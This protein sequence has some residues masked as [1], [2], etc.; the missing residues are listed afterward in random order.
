MKNFNYKLDKTLLPKV[1][2]YWYTQ[3]DGDCY[4][5]CS[6]G[7]IKHT[8]EPWMKAYS[9]Q[10]RSYTEGKVPMGYNWST[11]ESDKI[12]L[13]ANSRQYF[14][15]VKHHKDKDILEM[16]VCTIDTC[17]QPIPHEWRFLDRIFI[18]KEKNVY[19]VQGTR[20]IS[21]YHGE[22]I[23]IWG[24]VKNIISAFLRVDCNRTKVVNEFKKFIG[25]DY[26]IIGNGSSVAI[27]SIWRIQ[28]WF[29]T[30]QK[31]RGAGKQQKLTDKLVS[32]KLKPIDGLA[33][34]YP[35]KVYINNWG[36]TDEIS[37][38]VYFEP[39]DNEWLVLR[40]FVRSDNGLQEPWRAYICKDGTVRVVSKSQ[41]AEGW[42]PSQRRRSWWGD[43]YFFA[44]PEEAKE[45]TFQIKYTI[46]ELEKNKDTTLHGE[47]YERNLVDNLLV[48]LRFP[49]IEQLFKLGATGI[50]KNVMRSSTPKAE[51]KNQ[52]GG[53]YNEK[54]NG[55]LRKI[56]LTKPQLDAYIELEGDW[57]RRSA[58]KQMRE[59]FGNDLS[60]MDI[61]SFKKNLKMCDALCNRFYNMRAV[62]DAGIEEL[63]FIKNI[64]RIAQKHDSAYSVAADTLND[65]G[66]LDYNTHPEIDWLFDD[67]SDLV[68]AHDAVNA[69]R[70]RQEEERRARWDA[71]AK[72]RLKKQEE[73]R[74]KV[75][76]ERK[77]YNYEEENFI[78][79]LPNDLNEI[80]S[81]GSRQKICIGGYTDR[82]AM[83]NTNLFFLR[84][85]DEPDTP[86]YAIE[87]NNNKHIVQIHGYC[88]KWLGNDPDAI[89][90]VIRWLRKHG[91][92]C[93]DEILTCTAKG[94]GSCNDYVPMPQVD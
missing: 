2:V 79:R 75:D 80:I 74:K 32:M 94:Y 1:W 70:L 10:T 28:K 39:I 62:R 66:R 3:R 26:F 68:R 42:I 30:V 43:R 56:G 31:S 24:D 11:W 54:E 93:T 35:I 29:G 38:F 65:Y 19:N 67:F 9:G 8:P 60:H 4:L 76:E 27:D 86:F 16:S 7:K 6:T 48:A 23:Y 44:N 58:I 18:D 47:D 53:Y 40:A 37:N 13:R 89:P 90:T 69:L 77:Q 41:G 92:K 49:E 61:V 46:T 14:L 52:F 84:K 82:H 22:R 83:G 50:A 25:A 57:G 34:K 81:E 88:N 55:I 51:L 33:E 71:D 15:Y 78:I 45:S 20:I 91:I 17:R 36:G 85:V 64:A 59:Y 73:K 72:E 87:M 21:N 63:K 5:N 12:W